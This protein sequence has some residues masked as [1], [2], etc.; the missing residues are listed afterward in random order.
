LKDSRSAPL[1]WLRTQAN[2]LF[3][4]GATDLQMNLAIFSRNIFSIYLVVGTLLFAVFG[5]LAGLPRTVSWLFDY[6]GWFR[7]RA[8]LAP[9]FISPPFGGIDLS[10]WW[11]L[12]IFALVT[13]V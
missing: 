3:V 12:P 6:F 9:F 13:A 10:P 2:Y 7:L 1:Q 8:M 11:W 4:A 5:I